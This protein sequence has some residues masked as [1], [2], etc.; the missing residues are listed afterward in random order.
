MI[1]DEKYLAFVRTKPCARCGAPAP[2]DP[3]HI[4]SRMWRE[5]KRNDYLALPLCRPCH[6]LVDHVTAEVWLAPWKRPEVGLAE[7]VSKL[8]VEFFTR[9]PAR[10][11]LPI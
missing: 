7:D 3:H 6:T 5:V 8:L 4:V 11:A 9:E 1:V 10:A 2:S